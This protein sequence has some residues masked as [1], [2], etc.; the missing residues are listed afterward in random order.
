[1]TKKRLAIIGGGPGGLAAARVFLANAPGE[2]DID[3]FTNDVN[4]GGIWYFPHGDSRPS[5][6][7]YDHLETN[8]PKH[9]MQ[10]KGVPFEPHWFKYP[11]RHEVWVYLKRYYNQ[12]IR[13]VD[14]VKVHLSSEIVNVSKQDSQWSLEVIDHAND[15]T[16][17]VDEF[18]YVIAAT[19]HFSAPKVPSDVAGLEEWFTQ[20]DAFHS[21]NFYDAEFA[22]GKRVVV[23]GDGSSGQDIVNQTASVAEK[24]YQSVSSGK[25]DKRYYDEDPTVE[26]VTK[27]KSVDW[28]ERTV[29]LVD[30]T[31]LTKIDKL[32]YATGFLYDLGIFDSK[33]KQDLLNTNDSSNST[34]TTTTT[35]HVNNL[36]EQ[37]FYTKDSTLAFSLLPQLVVPFPL[38]ELQAS[39]IVKAFTGKLQVPEQSNS[40]FDRLDS[41]HNIPADKE[42]Q[43]YHELLSVL[44]SASDP[45]NP[46]EFQPETWDEDL[47]K[48]RSITAQEKYERNTQ[49]NRYSQEARS[50]GNQYEL[51]QFVNGPPPKGVE[52]AYP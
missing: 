45:N 2:F 42:I 13:D 14:D 47:V 41:G 35:S 25:D 33:L 7:L 34:T 38:A 10:Y 16:Y 17:R 48:E 46:D 22:K 30:G 36:W 37:I 15:D 52:A 51:I 32:V 28:K 6:V 12:F 27:I 29:T 4:V 24:V 49:L 20:K 8:I 43:Y 26:V 19:G 3:L 5:R 21:R 39:L 18:D 9:V 50:K 31:V 23:V 44:A 40:I 11:R 1:M